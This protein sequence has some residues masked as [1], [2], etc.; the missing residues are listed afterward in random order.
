MT[1]K[2]EKPSMDLWLEEA[3]K[4]PDAA[5]V[6]MYLTHNGTVRRTAKAKVR[7]GDETAADVT[8]MYFEYDAGKLAEVTEEARAM[9]GI[10]YIRTW[11]NEGYLEV[12]DDIMYVLV[13]GDI[14]P[15]VIDCLQYLVGRIKNECVVERETV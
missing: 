3:K 11:L 14:R 4:D 7:S 9:E 5:K 12:G 2:K 8:G 10:C 1:V 15:H 13:G 6:G